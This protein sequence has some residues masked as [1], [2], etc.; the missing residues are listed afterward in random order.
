MDW[1]TVKGF[2]RPDVRKVLVFLGFFSVSFLLFYFSSFIS[3]LIPLLMISWIIEGSP[4]DVFVFM[5]LIALFITFLHY[6]IS[7]IIAELYS[8]HGVK[9]LIVSLFLLSTVFIVMNLASVVS[10]LFFANPEIRWDETKCGR[11]PE[12]S[13]CVEVVENEISN[14]VMDDTEILF[15]GLRIREVEVVDVQKTT[16]ERICSPHS[17]CVGWVVRF[18][19]YTWLHIPVLRMKSTAD[20]CVDDEGN[21]IC[22]TGWGS[23][24][25]PW[26]D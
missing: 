9:T 20:R 15:T 8:R 3:A 21:H 6:V 25:P 12:Y 14:T 7:S 4:P 1:E 23:F 2:L 17:N 18:Q 5:L 11:F 26:C 16:A 24:M 13:Q 19:G 22:T 10:M